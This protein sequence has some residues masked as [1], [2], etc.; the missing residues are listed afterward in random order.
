MPY[1]HNMRERVRLSR[2]AR[3]RGRTRLLRA[4]AI[5]LL[6]ALALSAPFPRIVLSASFHG[7][8]VV[9]WQPGR[10]SS[11]MFESHA[12][13]DPIASDFYFVRST[14][15]FTG[16]RLLVSS[17]GPNGWSEPAPPSFAGD[18]VEA[19]P[20]FT[21][22]GRSLYF[23]STRSTDGIKRDDLDIWSVDRAPSGE[24]GT[25]ARLPA[26]VNSEGNE[27]FPRLAADGWL[28][29]GSNRAGGRGKTDIW[30]AREVGGT[31]TI[32]NLGPSVNTTGDEYEAEIARNGNYMIIMT[33]EGLYESSRRGG[34]WIERRPPP[35]PVNDNGGAVGALLLS[36]GNVL[37]SKES[38]SAL[39]GEFYVWRRA[40][41]DN[42]VRSCP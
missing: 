22:D 5:Q 28:Y 8:L 29:F 37:Y 27:W 14:P 2:D 19:D 15:D 1:H 6:V 23:I 11:P 20:W 16:W 36:N 7:S 30:R 12:A 18:G 42:G 34:A 32:E 33:N 24:W 39:S 17:C 26:P 35:A 4:F 13:F 41:A 10:I 40:A 25:P 21:L 3:F 31:W 38:R 9:P